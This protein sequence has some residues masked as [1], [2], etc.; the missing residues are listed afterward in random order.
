MLHLNLSGNP[1]IQGTLPATWPDTFPLLQELLMYNCSLSGQLPA[2]EHC[3]CAAV[4][5]T[6][7]TC[8]LLKTEEMLYVVGGYPK[9]PG[10]Q[11]IACPLMVCRASRPW[12]SD[13]A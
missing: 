10:A 4:R 12:V 13:S 1:G 9:A 8:P 2:G 3:M 7:R 11:L 6:S 5:W